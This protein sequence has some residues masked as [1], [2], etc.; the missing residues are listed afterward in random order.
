M[1]ISLFCVNRFFADFYQERIVCRK[2]MQLVD[3]VSS[4]GAKQRQQNLKGY[5]SA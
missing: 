4:F 2:S 1:R 3:S 5:G